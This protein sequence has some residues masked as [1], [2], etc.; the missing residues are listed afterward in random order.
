MLS[1]EKLREFE[2]RDIPETLT[3]RRA[4]LYALSCGL[5]ADPLDQHQL[6]FVELHRP[7]KVLPSMPVALG[8]TPGIFGDPA[9][10]ID[11]VRMVHGEEYVELFAPLPATGKVLGKTRLVDV[12]DKGKDRG[13]VLTIERRILD[14]ADERLLAIVTST[15]FLRGDGGFGGPA[16]TVATLPVMPETSP[17]IILDLPTRPEQALFY[18]LNGDENPLHADPEFARRAGFP[19]PILHGL[20]TF[21]VVTHALLKGLCDYEPGRLRKFGC[22]FTAP[23]YPGETLRTEIWHDGSFRA[24]VVERDTVV[25][26]YGSVVLTA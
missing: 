6:D 8:F 9:L 12:V 21:G 2:I 17:E 11:T 7:L 13:A 5:G 3:P 26:N 14:R 10:G 1:Y 18:R 15:V 25:V 16:G 22:R 20:C 19:R 4:A 23:V 24:R